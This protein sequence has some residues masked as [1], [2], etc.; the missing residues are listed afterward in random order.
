MARGYQTEDIQQKIIE[1]LRDSTT[2][3]SGVEISKQLKIN[4]ITLTKYLNIFA[5]EGILKKKNIGNVTLWFAEKGL[6]KFYFPDDYY[7][8]GPKYLELL[9]TGSENQVF[10]LIKNCLYSGA[11]VS[12]L[13]T[14]VILPA[15]LHVK[16]LYDDGKI[17]MSEEKLLKNIISNSIQIFTQLSVIPDPKKNVILIAGD[18]HNSL[19][20]E[21]TSAYFHSY[22]WNAYH[23]GDMSE[24]INVLFEI[25]LQKLLRKIWK[26]KPGIMIIV[27]FADTEEALNFFANSVNS[28]KKKIG[29][30]IKLVLC[31]KINKKTKI[32]SD[33]VTTD[34]DAI[35]EWSQ[36]NYEN[37]TSK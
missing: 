7:K 13:I 29:K 18:F 21:A 23:L 15:I 2:G 26:Q 33:L 32:P 22:E 19:I 1:L 16:K 36:S 10:S 34:I 11:T 6:E 17:G 12:K 31:G 37:L 24:S 35:V 3:M 8:L 28:L 20:S 9:T 4:R 30:N 5:A 25:D 14:E 27:I